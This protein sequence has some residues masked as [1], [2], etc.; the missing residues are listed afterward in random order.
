[1][2]VVLFI[3]AVFVCELLMICF[4]RPYEKSRGGGD[5]YQL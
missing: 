4:W 5:G 3:G 1:M 2:E